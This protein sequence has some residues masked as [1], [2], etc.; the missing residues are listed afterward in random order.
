MGGVR[1]AIEVMGTASA[2]PDVTL[3]SLLRDRKGTA[4]LE[5]RFRQ[6]ERQLAVLW[7][8]WAQRKANVKLQGNLRGEMESGGPMA[9]QLGSCGKMT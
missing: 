1:K 7:M 5:H 8:G 6:A 9:E 2:R 4:C 3:A